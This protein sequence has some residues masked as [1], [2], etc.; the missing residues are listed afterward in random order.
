MR[1]LILFMMIS[2]D[3]YFEGPNHDISWHTVDAEFNDFAAEQLDGMGGLLNL[4]L[5]KSRS[6]GNGNALLTYTPAT[7]QL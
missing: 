1:K 5:R 7:G 4:R 6:F 2:L 3:G